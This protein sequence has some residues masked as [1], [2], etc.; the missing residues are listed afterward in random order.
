[1]AGHQV[2]HPRPASPIKGEVSAGDWGAIQLIEWRETSL[3]MGEVGGG[4]STAF[5]GDSK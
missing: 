2:H 3:S 4:D 1:M 5:R